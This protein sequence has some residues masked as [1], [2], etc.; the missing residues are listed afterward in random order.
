MT[1]SE[2][3]K[4]AEEIAHQCVYDVCSPASITAWNAAKRAARLA[5]ESLEAEVK[6][7]RREA[8]EEAAMIVDEVAAHDWELGR[9]VVVG[10]VN[11]TLT[12]IRSRKSPKGEKP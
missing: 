5:L 11:R 12:A 1:P 8:L 7:A 6:K 3:D 10:F 2:L 4:K 9:E